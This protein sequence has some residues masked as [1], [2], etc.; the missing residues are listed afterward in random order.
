MCPSGCAIKGEGEEDNG[1]DQLH[2]LRKEHMIEEQI[3][4]AFHKS[5]V[6]PLDSH[7]PQ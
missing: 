4:C 7:H 6:T 3:K 1:N 2:P 5:T